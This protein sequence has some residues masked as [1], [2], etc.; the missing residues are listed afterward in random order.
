MYMLDTNIIIFCI[1]HRDS[2]CARRVASHLGKDI[3]I[4]V[5]TYTE[6]EFGIQ[7]S[8]MPEKNR[9]AVKRF[10]AGISI[11]DFD[12]D[13]AVDFGAVLAE[14]KQ[15]QRYDV[16]RDRDKMIAAHARSRGDVLVTNN[17]KDFKDIDRLILEDWRE[18]GDLL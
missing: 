8:I 5:I 13:A 10:L 4:S 11:V 3:C 7:N 18:I 9:E 14:L 17:I 16:A 15:K 6:L 12:I 1:R 2:V